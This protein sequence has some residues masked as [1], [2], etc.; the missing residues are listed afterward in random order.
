VVLTSLPLL[1]VYL[2]GQGR[3]VSGIVTGGVKG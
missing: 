2:F 1:V 3:I